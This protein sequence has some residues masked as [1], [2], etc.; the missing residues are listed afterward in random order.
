MF[1][2]LMYQGFVDTPQ[3]HGV[4]A[5]KRGAYFLGSVLLYEHSSIQW[6]CRRRK[7]DWNSYVI[8]LRF[9][10]ELLALGTCVGWYKVT[11]T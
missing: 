11:L 1:I 6:V 5:W 7:L 8:Y 10:L 4:P 9:A 2:Y 3:K